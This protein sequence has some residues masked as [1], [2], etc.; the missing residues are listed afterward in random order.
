MAKEKFM[1][2]IEGEK[3]KADDKKMGCR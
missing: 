2:R 3:M 1:P